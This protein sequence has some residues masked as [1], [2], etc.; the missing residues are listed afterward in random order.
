MKLSYPML[1]FGR[2]GCKPNRILKKEKKRNK[3]LVL[4]GNQACIECVMMPAA[5]KDQEEG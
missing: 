3:N 2:R 5:S 1:L 4:A